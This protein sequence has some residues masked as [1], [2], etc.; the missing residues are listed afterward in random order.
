MEEKKRLR[1]AT[2]N[3][4]HAVLFHS[5]FMTWSSDNPSNPA[6]APSLLQRLPLGLQ[7][8]ALEELLLSSND[9]SEVPRCL[10]SMRGLRSLSLDYN[11]LTALPDW[12]CSA[13]TALSSLDVSGNAL[14][15][16]P[17]AFGSGCLSSSLVS[18]QATS[19]ALATLPPSFIKLRCVR[20]FFVM[21]VKRSSKQAEKFSF[22]A[23]CQVLLFNLY[24]SC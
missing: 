8:P 22:R 3:K 6:S 4:L 5:I 15:Q 11:E 16:L 19:N 18:L 1:R 7:C 24:C 20:L 21:Q 14:Q 13:L 12:V 17:Q 9:L 10:Q 23:S 2:M